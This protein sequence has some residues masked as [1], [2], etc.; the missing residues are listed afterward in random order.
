VTSQPLARL[1][2]TFRDTLAA[3]AESDDGLLARLR[4]GRDPAAAEA[5]VRRHGPRILAA[6]RKVLGP[7]PEAEDAFQATF[8]VLLRNPA[9]VRRSASLGAWLY[10]VA[11][12][13]ALQARARRARRVD[14]PADLPARPE[15]PWS[16]ACAVLHEELDRLPDAV[17]LPLVL[18]Y[19]DGLSRDEA[20]QQLD[21]SLNS[22]KKSLEKGRE[23]LRRRLTRRGVTLS[24]GLLAAVAGPADGEPTPELVASVIQGGGRAAAIDLAATVRPARWP[25]RIGVGLAAGVLAVG[26]ALGMSGEPKGDPPAKDMPTKPAAPKDT[27]ADGPKGERI[28]FAGR[29]VDPDGKAVKGAKVSLVNASWSR[30]DPPMLQPSATTAADGRFDFAVPKPDG[31]LFDFFNATL[32]AWADGFGLGLLPVKREGSANAEIRVFLDL[33]VRGRVLNPQGKPLAAATVRVVELGSQATP[34]LAAWMKQAEG[35]GLKVLAP[36]DAVF[37]TFPH[38]VRFGNRSLPGLPAVS[39]DRDGR[40]TLTGIGRERVAALSVSGPGVATSEILIV[41]Q[42]GP[43]GQFKLVVDEETRLKGVGETGEPGAP[44]VIRP[45]DSTSPRSAATPVDKPET[46]RRPFYRVPFDHVMTPEQPL[47]GRVTDKETGKPIPGVRVSTWTPGFELFQVLTDKDGRY[48]VG[49][50]PPGSHGFDFEPGPDTPYHR[51]TGSGG[52]PDSIQPVRLDVALPRAPWVRGRVVDEKTRRPIAGAK[53]IYEAVR[54][55]ARAADYFER[56]QFVRIETQTAADGSF[57]LPGVPGRGWLVVY[58]TEPGL[59]AAERLV[60]GDS[61]RADPPDKIDTFTGIETSILPADFQALV[62]VDV[63]PKAPREYTITL[64]P[65]VHVPVSLTD[66]DGKPV[67]GAIALGMQPHWRDWSKPLAGAN[68]DVPAFNPDRPRTMVFYH[69][70]RDLATVVRPKKGDAGPWVIRMQPTATVIGTLVL[71]DGKPYPV[72]DLTAS[73]TYPGQFDTAWWPGRPAV[74]R[75]KTDAAGKFRITKVIGDVD[76]EFSYKVHGDEFD[77]SAVR[78]RAKPGETKDLGTIKT[79]PPRK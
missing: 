66:P 13:I 75:F 54:A 60:Q 71:P 25:R 42:P 78:F 68:F 69:P 24:T 43:T 65:G 10:G 1:V 39:T 74:T 61:D 44:E 63:D 76:Y 26:V 52:K 20:A 30:D 55:N 72:A 11:H 19:L 18:C 67:T 56:G 29:V 77:W 12:R 48:R 5:I 49:G 16:E 37:D 14:P 47:E 64:D 70:D 51:R 17:R 79:A 40:F 3:D 22:V 38:R 15:L 57:R 7:A 27:S 58:R 73:F 41:T 4:A 8:L 46:T 59:S 28:A 31:F 32:V 21:R 36:E 6:C 23:L 50:L 2:Q 34:D 35:P 9:A 33:P 45:K 53:V 62:A